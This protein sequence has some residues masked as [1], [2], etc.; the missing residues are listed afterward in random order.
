MSGARSIA[1]TLNHLLRQNHRAVLE[2]QLGPAGP[3][4]GHAHVH[5]TNKEFF[6]VGKIV[7]LLVGDVTYALS[8]GPHQDR[9][10]R[11]I[12]VT[13]YHEG[14]RTFGRGRWESFLGSFKD[15]M[16]ARNRRGARASVD[17]FF[18]MV[19]VL[20]LASARGKV[21]EIMRLLWRARPHA[22]SF[23]ARLLDHPKMIPA[24]DPMIPAIVQAVR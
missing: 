14:R 4:H 16:R 20:R 5:L 15:L 17:S 21:G 11:A 10:A 1:D 18:H 22:D 3:I 9:R 12:A 6:V 19:D 8:S 23:R 24:L 13:L 2:W 7:D